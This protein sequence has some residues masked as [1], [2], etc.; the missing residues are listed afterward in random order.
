MREAVG[1]GAYVCTPSF[2]GRGGFA[3][4][5]SAHASM[6]LR[7]QTL[8]VRRLERT[9]LPAVLLPVEL[10]ATGGGVRPIVSPR[11]VT[12]RDSR[13]VVAPAPESA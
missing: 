4:G 2:V 3:F 7:D 12:P 8:V 13:E 5:E 9:E 10:P 6:F 1:G 11:Q